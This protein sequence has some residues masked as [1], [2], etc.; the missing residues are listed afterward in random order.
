MLTEQSYPNI[1]ERIWHG[2]LPNGLAVRVI[3]KPGYRRSFA[4]F[5]TNYGGADRVFTVDGAE[6]RTPAGVAH[7]LEHKL[8][9]MPDGGNALNTLA[10]NGAQPNAFTSSAMT[11]YYFES[12]DGF[13]ENLKSL[14]TFVSTPYF[15]AESVAKEQGIIGQEIRMTEDTPGF[16]VYVNLMRSLY[17]TGPLR[18]SVAGTIESIAEITAQTLYDCHAAFYRPSN[19]ALAVVGDVDPQRVA[20]LAERLLPHESGSAPTRSYGITAGEAPAAPRTEVKMAVSA[21][22]FLFG[23]RLALS[24]PGPARLRDRLT[25]E[26]ALRYLMGKSSP[27]YAALYAEGLVR[28]D[29]SYELDQAAG[30]CVLL[31]GGE[32]RDPDAVMA[33]VLQQA[34]ADAEGFDAARFD[35][36]RKSLYGAYLRGLEDFDGLAVEQAEGVFNGCEPLQA[37]TVLGEITEAECRAFLQQHLRADAMALSIVS[38]A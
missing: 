18:D 6:H 17:R 23:T 31:I 11:A 24:E 30:E 33:R 27:L 3:V 9:D 32:S 8:F 5:A 4:L 14:L 25:G 2:T 19:M 12:T 16:V 13:E 34:A 7:Y 22:Q 29:F 36:V 15:T 1:G 37:F 38:P 10:Q 26:L 35:R 28:H 21:P 20:E